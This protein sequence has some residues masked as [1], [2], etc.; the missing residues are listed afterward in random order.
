MSFATFIQSPAGSSSISAGAGLI[1][2]ALGMIGSKRR[3]WE[4][5]ERQGKL[6]DRAAAQNQAMALFNQKLQMEMWEKTGPVGMMEQLKKAGLNPGLMYGMSGA[7]GG[8]VG[9]IGAEGVGTPT[10]PMRDDGSVGVAMGL[11]IARAAAEIENIKADTAKKKKEIPNI[12]ADTGEKKGRT[13]K[14]AAETKNEGLKGKLLELEED[15]KKVE[16]RIKEAT[17]DEVIGVIEN[18]FLESGRK[19][20]LM[21]QQWGLTDDMYNDIVE[22]QKQRAIEA[23][24]RNDLARKNISKTDAEIAE[25][26]AG[27]KQRWEE[28]K[29]AQQNA[30]TRVS[31]LEHKKWVED[32]ADSYKLSVETVGGIIER[33][34]GASKGPGHG[35]GKGTNKSGRKAPPLI[36]KK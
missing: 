15:L 7:G 13:L 32:I 4:Q 29:I 21:A 14:I 12:E 25:I 5:Y 31:E 10:A 8:T 18:A 17:E 20:D 19:L 16:V 11:Q 24:L 33:V 9:A 28:L 26:Y 34:L 36:K 1:G 35:Q 3:A 27:I 30:D 2:G 23:A 22:E 6:M